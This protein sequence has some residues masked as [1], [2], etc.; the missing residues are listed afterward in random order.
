MCSPRVLADKF[1]KAGINIHDPRFG[2]W[3]ERSSHLKNAAEYLRR[4]QEFFT[5]EPTLEQILQF[6]RELGVKYG[7][8]VNF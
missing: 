8:Q 2:V 3:W 7:F 6:G 5:H 1:Q 4:W